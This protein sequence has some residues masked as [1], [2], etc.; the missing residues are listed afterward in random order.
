M[1]AKLQHYV[2]QLLLSR[3]ADE[4]GLLESHDLREGR[5]FRQPCK[6]AAAE[7]HFYRVENP[8]EDTSNEI[9]QLL[10]VIETHGSDALR[11]VVDDAVWP[12]SLDDRAAL[13]AL[14]AFQAARTRRVRDEIFELANDVMKST[15]A[16]Q[17]K[18]GL[19]QALTA[20]GEPFTEEELDAAWDFWEDLDGWEVQPHK[21]EHLRFMGDVVQEIF[22]VFYEQ[23]RIGIIRFE[24][25]SLLT[26]DDGLGIYANVP[27]GMGVG[28]LN[29]TEVW[30]PVG[31]RA[32]IGFFSEAV[33]DTDGVIE[34]STQ[35]ARWINTLVAH[36]T[37]RYVYHHPEDDG[38]V[39]DLLVKPTY[40]Q[41]LTEG[42]NFE[43][44]L[45]ND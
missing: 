32:A 37:R 45:E 27:E 30:L 2:P 39:N 33:A 41:R 1:D 43:E 15:V 16:I 38:L 7:T 36:R 3:F 31:R 34:P 20:A 6:T 44:M 40:R 5:T 19:R 23:R 9:E 22:P 26:T 35:K 10:S 14:V 28:M 17:G 12:I 29:A 24:R 18:E 42:I 8:G 21:H 13:A 25:R 4:R 11:H